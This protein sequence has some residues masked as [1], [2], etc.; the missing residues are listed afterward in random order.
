M[1]LLGKT[2]ELKLESRDSLRNLNH[3]SFDET[4]S[5]HSISELFMIFN[6]MCVHKVNLMSLNDT[7]CVNI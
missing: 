4:L 2:T 7:R 1:K 6:L 3:I 5:L